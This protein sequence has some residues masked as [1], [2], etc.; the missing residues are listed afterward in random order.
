MLPAINRIKIRGSDDLP[1]AP[2]AVIF[3]VGPNN[4]GK[5]TFLNEILAVTSKGENAKW[6]EAI[7]WSLGTRDEYQ[8]YIDTHFAPDTADY[9]KEIRTG[10]QVGRLDIT[11]F[12]ER[13][14]TRSPSFL[15]R[16]L[17]A[18]SRIELANKTAAPSVIAKH[19]LHPY[20]AF[21]FDTSLEEAFSIKVAD[22]FGKD[23]RINRTG[24]EVAGYLGSAPQ[25]ERLSSEYEQSI[26]TE[27]IPIEQFGDGVRSYTG[28]LLNAIADPRP[29]TIIDE[30]EA[31]LHPP[32]A[33]KLGYEIAGSA[34]ST[35]QQVFVATHSAEFIQGALASANPNIHFLYLDHSNIARPVF[36]VDRS[37]VSEFG[38]KPFL[39]NTNA[40]D[41]MFYEQVVICEGEADIMFFKWI[42]GNTPLERNLQNTFWISSYGKSAIP[43]MMQDLARLGVESRCIF[44][45]DVLLSLD[46]LER[47]CAAVSIDFGEHRDALLRLAREIRVP[48]AAEALQSIQSIVGALDD[49]ADDEPTR[50]AA[51]RQVKKLAESLGKSWSLKTTGLRL[52]PKGQSYAAVKRFL[53]LLREK[54]VIILEE[55]EIENYMP[56]IGGHGQSWVRAAI[57]NG[58]QGLVDQDSLHQQ[59]SALSS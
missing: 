15:I 8:A 5:S 12:Y 13:Y 17:N 26:I 46:I 22:A 33:R 1:L 53:A 37:T 11:R 4:G 27:M 50:L 29:V 19:Q 44:D 49:V 7:S 23:F 38:Q 9:L 48:P 25:G 30:P 28:I 39:A 52:I 18:Q 54:G 51:I 41:A 31:F 43:G 47:V 42:S 21:F 57:E 24:S 3:V 40:L 32:Q 35:G 6:I 10:R 55:G 36:Y 58:S 34:K 59:L 14:W 56:Q 2:G 20:H 16:L 45:L